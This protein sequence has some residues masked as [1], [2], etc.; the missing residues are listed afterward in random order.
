MEAESVKPNDVTMVGV[1]SACTKKLDLEYGRWVCLYIERNG[2]SVNLTLSNAIIDMFTKCG[3]L[4]DA[5]RLFDMM[6]EKDIVTWTT[7][8]HGYAKLGE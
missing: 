2:I 1:L 3:S 4:E 7:M 6:E 8:L 5:K